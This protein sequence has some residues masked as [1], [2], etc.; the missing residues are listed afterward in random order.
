MFLK[1][2]NL[3]S[4]AEV[5]I[6]VLPTFCGAAKPSSAW[7]ERVLPIADGCACLDMSMAFEETLGVE[8]VPS[9]GGTSARG[10]VFGR[11]SEQ[12]HM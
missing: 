10:I 7:E 11:P 5:R 1:V 6:M 8:D 3:P 9:A 2:S 4:D 12:C